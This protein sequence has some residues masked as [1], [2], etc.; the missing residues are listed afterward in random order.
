MLLCKPQVSFTIKR[1][2]LQA[3]S[4]KVTLGV[5]V[6][7][8]VAWDYL[9]LVGWFS[10]LQ[11]WDWIQ[12]HESKVSSFSKWQPQSVW[13]LDWMKLTTASQWN[14]LWSSF[15]DFPFRTAHIPDSTVFVMHTVVPPLLECLC[16]SLCLL[17]LLSVK[18]TNKT[19]SKLEA[20]CKVL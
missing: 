20:K 6:S 4:L 13:L 3:V 19:Q 5:S 11:S 2:G 1:A 10:F 9:G 15:L 12:V 8:V 17:F 14:G 18:K 7:L 16:G